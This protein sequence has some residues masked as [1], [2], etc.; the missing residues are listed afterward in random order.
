M[1]N[2]IRNLGPEQLVAVALIAALVAILVT[3]PG[4]CAAPLPDRQ[5]AAAR[6]EDV[7][8]KALEHHR[9]FRKA[10]VPHPSYDAEGRAE[11]E[12]TAGAIDG[13]LAEAYALAAELA[14]QEGAK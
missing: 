11:V 3:A 7:L 4:C 9:Q 13:E 1:R 8:S 14:T 2:W 12:A 10:T 6:L 5:R